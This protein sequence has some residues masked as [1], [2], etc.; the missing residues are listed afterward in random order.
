MW[1]CFFFNFYV[2]RVAPRGGAA[3]TKDK[4]ELVWGIEGF[5]CGNPDFRHS[6]KYR[7]FKGVWF[8]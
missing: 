7:G 3:R 5:W 2:C 6:E 1:I 8:V 4:K